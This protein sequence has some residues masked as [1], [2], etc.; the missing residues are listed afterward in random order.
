MGLLL[1]ALWGWGATPAPG[2]P[3]PPSSPPPGPGP[4]SPA[5]QTPRS[6]GAQAPDCPRNSAAAQATASGKR[7]SAR[8]LCCPAGTRRAAGAPRSPEVPSP[9]PHQARHVWLRESAL[10]NA[11]PSEPQAPREATQICTRS[12]L[13]PS[14]IP[15]SLCEGQPSSPAPT[16]R[17]PCPYT[18]PRREIPEAQS[19]THRRTFRNRA[20][21]QKASAQNPG[22]WRGA[23]LAH[24]LLRRK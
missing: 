21:P 3:A 19:S 9:R 14:S 22:F 15:G 2:L 20:C 1:P 12:D 6:P 13:R 16:Y 4:P 5:A 8:R 17:T 11:T 23:S 18:T 24:L 7:G 10:C